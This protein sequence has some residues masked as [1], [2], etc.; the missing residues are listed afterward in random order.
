M[1]DGTTPA[2][3]LR[4]IYLATGIG[5]GFA[6]L[7]TPLGSADLEASVRYVGLVVQLGGVVAALWTSLLDHEW[8]NLPPPWSAL[9]AHVRRL[10]LRLQRFATPRR[11]RVHHRVVVDSVDVGSV[12][13]SPRVHVGRGPTPDD[14]DERVSNLDREMGRVYEQLNLNSDAITE[15][16]ERAEKA[17]AEERKQREER[18]EQLR[19]DIRQRTGEA[20]H[21]DFRALVMIG[22]GSIVVG[23]AHEISTVLT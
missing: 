1:G 11:G 19:S 14:L 6:I 21:L 23:L 4:R 18:E 17:L 7:L 12:I 22:V 9:A 15:A 5:S 20:A 3:N 10:L 16:R 8:A 2:A 13:S